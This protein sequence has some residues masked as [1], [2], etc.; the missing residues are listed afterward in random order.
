MLL[1]NDKITMSI[2]YIDFAKVSAMSKQA[3]VSPGREPQEEMDWSSF[4]NDTTDIQ[5]A[6]IHGDP[7]RCEDVIYTADTRTPLLLHGMKEDAFVLGMWEALTHVI[8]LEP[9]MHQTCLAYLRIS[10]PFRDSNVQQLHPVWGRIPATAMVMRFFRRAEYFLYIDTDATLALPNHSPT[11]M[12]ESLA[13]DGYGPNATFEHKR[14]GLIV[15]KP[16]NGWLCMHCQQFGLGHGCFNS[17][18]LLWRRSREAIHVLK[19]WWEARHDNGNQNFFRNNTEQDGDSYMQNFHG[20][21]D[22][23]NPDAGEKMSEQNRLMYI[24]AT[25]PAMQE[26]IWPVPRQLSD[27]S[28]SASCPDTLDEGHLPCLQND[29]ALQAEWNETHKATCFVNHFADDKSLP[30]EVMKLIEA[31]YGKN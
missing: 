21:S 29:R 25:Y 24:Y 20:W 17:G 2:E 12:Y 8:Q 18:V 7:S 28:H 23:V 30:V 19:T 1:M 16:M 5:L 22:P 10:Q 14:P 27:S 26:A 11:D 4:F 9:A 15:N 3:V 6:R 31:S 13:Y